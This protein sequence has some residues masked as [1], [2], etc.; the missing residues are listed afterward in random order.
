MAGGVVRPRQP[1]ASDLTFSARPPKTIGSETQGDV[2]RPVGRCTLPRAG[3][4]LPRSGRM[5]PLG[6]QDVL[7]PL[8]G[9]AA[10]QPGAEWSG[11]SREAP[12][13][14]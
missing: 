14:L 5:R 2:A 6:D 11:A 9:A 7:L 4:L 3:L 12:P 13:R 10:G 8:C 1:T